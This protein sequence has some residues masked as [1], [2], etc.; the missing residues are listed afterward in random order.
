MAQLEPS[1]GD[2]RRA[3]VASRRLSKP[4]RGHVHPTVAQFCPIGEKALLI[5]ITTS[6]YLKEILWAI[7]KDMGLGKR[8]LKFVGK[9]TDEELAEK[10][11]IPAI[12]TTAKGPWLERGSL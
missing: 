6:S 2:R 10:K 9:E 12:W 1:E 3:L 8:K 4:C 5:G 7:Q 11:E